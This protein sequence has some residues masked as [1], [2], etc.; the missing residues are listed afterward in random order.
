MRRSYPP[1]NTLAAFVEVAKLRSF[2]K[3]ADKLCVTHSAISQS[4]KTLESSLG[5]DVFV[6]RSGKPVEFTTAGE[7]YFREIDYAMRIII[8][9]TR[10]QKIHSTNL[11]QVT[12]NMMPSMALFWF[13]PRLPQF[14]ELYPKIDVR[15]S[16]IDMSGE[17]EFYEK[18]ADICL[19]YGSKPKWENCQI[20]LLFADKLC[21][22]GASMQK[23]KNYKDALKNHKA[24]YINHDLRPNDWK[25]W[26]D[27]MGVEEPPVDQRVYFSSTIQGIQAVS[28]GLGVFVTHALF[29]QEWLQLGNLQ[30]LSDEIVNKGDNF[31]LA[32]PFDVEDENIQIL[33]EWIRENAKDFAF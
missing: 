25:L 2:S 18:T 31:Y 14:Q 4:I 29:I 24:I 32:S 11:D 17:F 27:H 23:Y 16:S 10:D 19:T 13:I 8:D 21:F 26:C 3:A 20:E 12:I 9:A 5:H 6:R 22:I 30:L 1:L 7:T 33:L 28:S 15:V